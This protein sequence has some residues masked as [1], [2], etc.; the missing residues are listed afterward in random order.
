VK[1]IDRLISKPETLRN[2]A[3]LIGTDHGTARLITHCAGDAAGIRE[4]ISVAGDCL[5]LDRA[6][7]TGKR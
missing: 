2:C 1:D 4:A 3:A 5:A 7:T 6:A